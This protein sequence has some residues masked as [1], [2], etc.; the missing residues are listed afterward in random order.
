MPQKVHAS[1]LWL[2]DM[3]IKEYVAN[4]TPYNVVLTIHLDVQILFQKYISEDKNGENVY[5]KLEIVSNMKI[6]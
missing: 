1:R 3:S 2:I 4:G 6:Y 5:K